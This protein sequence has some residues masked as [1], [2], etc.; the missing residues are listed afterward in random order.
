MKKGGSIQRARRVRRPTASP[1][2]TGSTVQ[3]KVAKGRPEQA[4]RAILAQWRGVD[5]EPLERAQTDAARPLKTVLP[6]VLAELGLEQRQ[7]E[8]EVFKAW[9]HLVD[10][11]VTA[12]ARPTGLRRGTLFV[13][14]DSS[15]WLAEIV[16][17]RRREILERLQHSFGRE[18]IQ[19]ISWRAS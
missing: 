10:P 18:L 3:A 6:K 14:V 8:A 19:R 1:R 11:Q 2:P 16:G 7:T 12:H 5:L 9:T 17:Y 4:R 13:A 15:V